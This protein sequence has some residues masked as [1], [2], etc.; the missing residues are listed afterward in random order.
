[1]NLD[2]KE[3]AGELL[4]VLAQKL[5]EKKVGEKTLLNAPGVRNNTWTSEETETTALAAL[6]FMRTKPGSRQIE[7]LIQYLL[8]RRGAYG[9]PR[10]RPAVGCWRRSRDFTPRANLPRTI[11]N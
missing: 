3:F 1:M 9:L 8:N 11:T 5:A 4:D 6:A 10:P 7:G 2:R